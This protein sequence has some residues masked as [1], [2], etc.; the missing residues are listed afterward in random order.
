MILA[1]Q[2]RPVME[3]FGTE[4]Y[5]PVLGPAVTVLILAGRVSS[6]IG[7]E[8]GSKLRKQENQVHDKQIE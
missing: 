2:S 5:L 8:L 3:R 1:I 7:T 6:G 4:M